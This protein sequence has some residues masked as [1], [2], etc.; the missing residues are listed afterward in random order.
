VEAAVRRFKADQRKI[1]EEAARPEGA[2]AI[3]CYAPV[4]R[5]VDLGLIEPLNGEPPNARTNYWRLTSAGRA[6]LL[7]RGWIKESR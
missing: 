5:L 4:L 1:L 6:L 2:H 7:E 3:R